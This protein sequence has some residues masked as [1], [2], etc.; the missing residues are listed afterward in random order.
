MGLL[1]DC[2]QH[3][4]DGVQARYK[5]LSWSMDK[6]GRLKEEL[7]AADLVEAAMIPIGNTRRLILRPT[8]RASKLLQLGRPA[9]RESLAHEFWKH[10]HAEQLRQEGWEIEIEAP[11]AGGRVDVLATKDGKSLA[12]EV[13][14]GKSDVVANVRNCLRSRFNQI[15]VVATSEEARDT[16]ERHLAR[17]GMLIRDRVRIANPC[18]QSD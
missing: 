16:V 11:R 9:T 15:L 13:E 14:T 2:I 5:R 17:V 7:L 12:I 3:P 10:Y 6:G 4:T 8:N 18:C 1:L